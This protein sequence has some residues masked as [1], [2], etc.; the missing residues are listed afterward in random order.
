V[1]DGAL[2]YEELI[3][4]ILGSLAYFAPPYLNRVR[5][6]VVAYIGMKQILDGKIADVAS[7]VPHYIRRSD[8]EIKLETG[9]LLTNVPKKI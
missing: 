3:R 1:G 2:V 9:D 6:S 5:A 7:L 4:E 8:A